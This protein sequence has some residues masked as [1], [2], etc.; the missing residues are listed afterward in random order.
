MGPKKD[1]IILYSQPREQSSG[2]KSDV[3]V[4]SPPQIGDY[5]VFR[6]PYGVW[7]L[8]SLDKA[9]SVR[10]L[11]RQLYF[12]SQ[13]YYLRNQIPLKKNKKIG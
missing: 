4:Y 2:I 5:R 11:Q 13:S 12:L 6:S 9:Q 10:L 8:S 1:D 7:C 3:F